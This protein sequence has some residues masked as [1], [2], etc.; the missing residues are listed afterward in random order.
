[1]QPR[2]RFQLNRS[3]FPDEWKRDKEIFLI[4]AKNCADIFRRHSF[5]EV[6]PMFLCDKA[7]IVQ[8]VQHDPS[9]LFFASKMLQRD[10]DVQLMVFRHSSRGVETVLRQTSPRDT[11]HLISDFLNE[12]ESLLQ[13]REIFCN[14]ILFGLRFDAGSTLAA[15]DQ[16]TETS[17]NFKT[18]IAECLGVPLGK[19]LRRLRQARQ[20]IKDVLPN[21]SHRIGGR[22]FFDD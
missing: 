4:I 14:T 19:Q 22:D 9:L 5:K 17:V 21:F 1:V 11:E 6:S 15:L 2:T 12:V 10:F 16:G 7:F 3:G 20:N 8:T 13:A 18:C